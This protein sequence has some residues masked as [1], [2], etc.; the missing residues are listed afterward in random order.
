MDNGIKD[1]RGQSGMTQEELARRAGVTRQTII[2]LEGGK[3]NPSLQ[4][5]F[6]I[7]KVFSKSIE[8]VFHHG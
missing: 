6:R 7:S 3:Y 8:E 5:A 1:L 2:A 4:L